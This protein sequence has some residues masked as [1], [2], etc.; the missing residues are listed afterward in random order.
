[1]V[2]VPRI[3]P[4]ERPSAHSLSSGSLYLAL[5][6]PQLSHPPVKGAPTI[7]AVGLVASSLGKAGLHAR[8]VLVFISV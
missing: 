2:T 1:M 8:V 3:A 6:V 5:L 4:G 7:I